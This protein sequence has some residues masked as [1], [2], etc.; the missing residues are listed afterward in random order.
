LNGLPP[1]FRNTVNVTRA[2][3]YRYLWID[4]LCILQ[5]SYDSWGNE[6]S[7]MQEYY[8]NAILTI[9]LDDMEGGH[10]G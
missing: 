2:L 7:K 6:S 10:H 3:G 5:G 9:P 8:M 4:S 1:T